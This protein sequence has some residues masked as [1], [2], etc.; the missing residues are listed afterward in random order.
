MG[1]SGYHIFGRGGF[2]NTQHF[3]CHHY[4]LD[5]LT[6]RPEETIEALD[7]KPLIETRGIA[8]TPENEHVEPKKNHP[9]DLP[10]FHCLVVQP[11][12]FPGCICIWLHIDT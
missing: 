8:Y 10:N 6:L 7:L 4:I 5:Q 9:I 2:F 1:A 11:V 3:V 12:D